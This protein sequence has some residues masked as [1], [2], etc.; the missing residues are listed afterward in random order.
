MAVSI[1]QARK[2][3]EEAAISLMAKFPIVGLGLSKRGDD[4]VVKVNLSRR[5]P[6]TRLPRF[7]AGV[8]I[9]Y[10]VVGSIHPQL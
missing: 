1:E 4:Y 8:P 2:A 10:E 7:L 6:V 3:K 9:I 5:I